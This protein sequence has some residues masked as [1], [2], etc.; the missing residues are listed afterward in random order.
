MLHC[1]SHGPETCWKK[2]IEVA[3][4]RLETKTQAVPSVWAGRNPF[5]ISYHL[6]EMPGTKKASALPSWTLLLLNHDKY[7]HR[8]HHPKFLL[9]GYKDITLPPP[10]KNPLLKWSYCE[11]GGSTFSSSLCLSVSPYFWYPFLVSEPTCHLA[12]SALK[13]KGNLIIL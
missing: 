8:L 1:N 12:Q 5:S 7:H 13:H 6:S 9:R 3:Q 10:Q 2:L 11:A 4:L